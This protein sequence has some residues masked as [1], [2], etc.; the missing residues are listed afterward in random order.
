MTTSKPHQTKVHAGNS[1][2]IP[3]DPGPIRVD[4]PNGFCDNGEE[5]GYNMP[6]ETCGGNGYIVEEDVTP[7]D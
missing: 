1:I 3:G 5:R 2:D 7:T 4:C 6:C